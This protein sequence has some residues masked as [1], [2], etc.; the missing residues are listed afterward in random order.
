VRLVPDAEEAA[1]G[2]ATAEG[3]H[4]TGVISFNCGNGSFQICRRKVSTESTSSEIDMYTGK[5]GTNPALHALLQVMKL[6]PHPNV[7]PNPVSAKDCEA[8]V[9]KIKSLL[10]PAPAWVKGAKVVSI[11]GPNSISAVA[12]RSLAMFP[13]GFL[14]G[15]TGT[16]V[17]EDD[18]PE[19]LKAIAG[20]KNL[21]EIAGQHEFAESQRLV[22]PKVALFTAICQH[23]ELSMVNFQ[24]SIGSCGGVMVTDAFWDKEFREQDAPAANAQAAI[25]R[26]A[27]QKDAKKSLL[28]MGAAGL[29]SAL[30]EGADL[31]DSDATN[32]RLRL[33]WTFSAWIQAVKLLK[34]AK[35]KPPE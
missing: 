6:E 27:G 32:K 15:Y 14:P 19:L 18:I 8:A 34:E 5:V 20:K 28:Q 31:D 30:K 33:Y 1:L 2:L 12:L 11:G 24:H 4:G 7:N 9:E 16:V 21:E 26:Q 3:Y 25:A 13:G 17:L 35:K 23:C 29:F 10:P 22:V